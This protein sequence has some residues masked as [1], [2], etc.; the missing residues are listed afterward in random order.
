MEAALQE[1]SRIW[2][3]IDELAH[4]YDISNTTF[5]QL[6]EVLAAHLNAVKMPGDRGT[7]RVHIK[8]KHSPTVLLSYC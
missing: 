7:I 5:L 2:H 8:A 4:E 3:K 1:G 6:K